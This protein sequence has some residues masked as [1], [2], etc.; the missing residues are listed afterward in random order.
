MNPLSEYQNL[1]KRKTL[2]GKDVNRGSKVTRNKGTKGL[3]SRGIAGENAAASEPLVRTLNRTRAHV[4]ATA[5]GLPAH[6]H[7]TDNSVDVPNVEDVRPPIV[8]QN[9]FLAMTLKLHKGV[10]LGQGRLRFL[11]PV[12]FGEDRTIQG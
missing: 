1:E 10:K 5:V 9:S 12:Q 8:E 11:L 4:P 3:S 6:K 2:G 7:G